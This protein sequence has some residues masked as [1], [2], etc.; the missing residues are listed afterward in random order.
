MGEV[1][2]AEDRVVLGVDDGGPARA[3]GHQRDGGVQVADVRI[4][5][6]VRQ[7]QRLGVALVDDLGRRLTRYLPLRRNR[8]DDQAQ[9]LEPQVA[10]QIVGD[11][12]VCT[13]FM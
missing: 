7:P 10:Q 6:R 11:R 1:D 5:Q 9:R 12:G 13:L 2:D 3:L 4:L 8:R